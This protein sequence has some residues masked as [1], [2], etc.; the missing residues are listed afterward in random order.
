[1]LRAGPLR[2]AWAASTTTS[3]TGHA[4]LR[5]P[6]AGTYQ[7]TLWKPMLARRVEVRPDGDELVLRLPAPSPPTASTSTLRVR[8]KVPRR[9]YTGGWVAHV[10][11]GDDEWTTVAPVEGSGQAVARGLSPGPA[12]VEIPASWWGVNARPRTLTTSLVAGEETVVD[13]DLTAP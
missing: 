8:A 4:T 10:T 9:R 5:T 13:V 11:T 3:A 6:A 7:L 2:G 12:R 1:M